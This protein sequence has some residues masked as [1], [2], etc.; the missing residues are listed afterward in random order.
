MNC[1]VRGGSQMMRKSYHP[2]FKVVLLLCMLLFLPS[3][4]ILAEEA[5]HAPIELRETAYISPEIAASI[6]DEPGKPM[7]ALIL[8]K[9]QADTP[10]MARITRNLLEKTLRIP[11]S[12]QQMKS[13]CRKAVVK[14]L[15]DVADS[16]QGPLLSQL[17][18]EK[19]LGRV[20]NLK[21][22]Y[23]V[24]MLYIEAH[25]TVI[26]AL[27]RNPAVKSILPNTP[28]ELQESGT[29]GK[30]IPAEEIAP[31]DA[32]VEW[33]IKKIKADQVWEQFGV[34]GEGVVVGIIDSGAY[35]QHPAL[36]EKYRGYDP[37]KPNTPDNEYNWHDVV[38]ETSA[39]NDC[40]GSSH[41][42]HV[43]GIIVA[44]T[45]TNI[46]GVAP[47]AR[48]I[49][50]NAFK[51]DGSSTPQHCIDAAQYM[52]APVS[53]GGIPNPD[54]APDILNCSW[55]MPPDGEQNVDEWFRPMVNSL[56]SAGI[57]PIF[58]AGNAK[59]PPAAV[60]SIHSPA[61]YP[62]SLSVAAVN[63]QN[64]RASFSNRGPAIHYPG[65]IKPDISA[66]GVGICS[67]I[68]SGNYGSKD[69]TS[70]ATPH[71][72]GTAALMLSYRPT[73]DVN[74][75]EDTIRETAVPLT[76]GA[77]TDSPNYGYGYGLV[78]AYAAIEA[79]GW[80]KDPGLEAAIREELDIPVSEEITL[81]DLE[82][83]EN[84]V[85]NGRNIKTLDG[86]QHAVSLTQLD[87]SNNEITD[88]A[89]LVA[90][91][92]NGGLG[93]GDEVDL[94][95]NYLD[96]RDGSKASKD[97]AALEA[98]G[99]NV[100]YDPQKQPILGKMSPPEWD[101]RK[102]K[103]N[104]I[105]FADHY[106]LKLYKDN[107]E[108]FSKTFN[109]SLTEYDM[110]GTIDTSGPGC[111]T[112]TIQ[113]MGDGNPWVTGEPSNHSAIL[114]IIA[115]PD[116]NL[117][118]LLKNI[119]GIEKGGISDTDMA[120]LT[121]IN[122]IDTN[123]KIGNLTGIEYAVNLDYIKLI[124]Q[125]ISNIGPLA[126]LTNLY[127][128]NLDNNDISDISPLISNI[129][130]GGF[131]TGDNEPEISLVNNCLS[132]DSNGQT[133][134]FIN[135]LLE[136][137]I[138]VTY[139][140]QRK[141][142]VNSVTLNHGTLD[143]KVGDTPAILIATIHPHNATNKKVTWAT[144]NSAVARVDQLGEVEAISSGTT[145]ITVKTEDGAHVASCTV[146]VSRLANNGDPLE[147]D[148]YDPPDN[149]KN[150]AV[151]KT[152]SIVFN[153]DIMPGTNYDRIILKDTAQNDQEIGLTKEIEGR[154]IFLTPVEKLEY[155]TIYK[156]SF[157]GEAV[158][159]AAGNK[160]AAFKISFRTPPEPIPVQSVSLNATHL[161]LFCGGAT[162][163]LVPIVE[164]DN[165]SEWECRW[166]SSEPETATVTGDRAR[167][168]I[169]TPLAS[170]SAFITAIISDRGHEHRAT[171]IVDA[172][173]FGDVNGNGKIEVG[174]AIILLRHIVGLN[175]LTG[176]YELA[177]KVNGEQKI[178]V[179]D[180]ISILRYIVQL[181]S[182]FPAEV[183]MCN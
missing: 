94:R 154:K 8:L 68:K 41:G 107:I 58:A 133:M 19:L 48:W 124:D 150:V 54:M 73:L 47:G 109:A 50:A 75:L 106:R 61:M 4:G 126:N 159:D 93:D 78:D 170:G 88:I 17:N 89:P 129:D 71:I 132:L 40:L 33:N 91:S 160:N 172:I 140:P 7:E 162:A 149:E 164:P 70:M 168:G 102:I 179:S 25:P 167:N 90:N 121:Q 12:H 141:I 103:W 63:N 20:K 24:N 111:Y 62:E 104:K 99:V 53:N 69:G 112:A 52:L 158:K 2:G 143:L 34:T 173:K 142:P 6:I 171:C 49:A 97:I 169:I 37:D 147:I 83:L 44:S 11:A 14:S 16:T 21:S 156:L 138:K 82:T 182:Q 116:T 157:P 26:M 77:D 114:K 31:S 9:E 60:S 165:A 57:L 65:V 56:R 180:A 22:F 131:Q 74:D 137:G 152:M 148:F 32:T 183:E 59:S 92:N 119:I 118:N 128:L 46:Y 85:A 15:Q 127:Y 42:T 135:Q 108:V 115:V 96:L 163:T 125:N 153:K 29:A 98:N 5:D 66:P 178:S 146:N 95:N 72:V 27:S 64:V 113:A 87:L 166:E 130:A 151:N 10:G 80:I 177:G 144:E 23:I 110:A 51:T 28:F 81:D 86:L 120:G 123:K 181:I 76:G 175:T 1:C 105:N 79:W 45:A 174:D 84:L 145:K 122:Y 36:K 67:T 39:P 38:Y 176:P 13:I 155:D 3:F 136:C 117:E 30:I 139:I 100:L 43:T 18:L 134:R 161:K 55:G 35:W 101:G